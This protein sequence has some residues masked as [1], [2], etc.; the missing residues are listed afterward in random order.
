MQRCD[1]ENLQPKVTHGKPFGCRIFVR[2]T[3]SLARLGC[4]NC[5]ADAKK[6]AIG[7]L[8]FRI[9]CLSGVHSPP[10]NMAENS[11]LLFLHV[12][13]A[14]FLIRILITVEASKS[15]SGRQAKDLLNA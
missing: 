13:K 1:G 14:V 3:T 12:V 4:R 11:Q 9:H 2:K 15:N 7:G 10:E 8:E 5:P 6:P